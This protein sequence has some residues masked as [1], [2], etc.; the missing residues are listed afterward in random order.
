MV[1][2]GSIS[3]PALGEVSNYWGAGASRKLGREGQSQ[4]ASF[5][6]T[7]AERRFFMPSA[8]DP[9]PMPLCSRRTELD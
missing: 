1:I 7:V 4:A 5:R 2:S 8:S 3:I 9:S 6:N